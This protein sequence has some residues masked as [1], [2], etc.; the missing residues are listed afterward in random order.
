MQNINEFNANIELQHIYLEAYAERYHSLRQYF[1]AY[2][3]YRHQLV[4]RQGKPDWEQIF[5]V[6]RRTK[7]AANITDR[8]QTVRELLLPLSVLTGKLKT[9]VRDE[10]LT[11]EAISQLLD[12]SLEYI[13][14][15]RQEWQALKQHGWLEAM[16]PEYYQPTNL[17]YLDTN[18]RFQ[19][20]GIEL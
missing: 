11:I 19:R 2:Y 13:I 15:G 12:E 8:K 20:V 4:T 5:D 17:S 3:C 10:R 16:P 9:L 18:L 6:A 14:L 7:Q 1:E